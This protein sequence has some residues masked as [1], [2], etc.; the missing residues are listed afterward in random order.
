MKGWNIMGF[1]R[2]EWHSGLTYQQT[3]DKCRT[4]FRYTDYS[5]DYRPWYADGYIDC[6]KCKNHMRH[7]E[8]YAINVPKSQPVNPAFAANTQQTAGV[9]APAQ[10][11]VRPSAPAASVNNK[12]FT[13]VFCVQCGKKY[14]EGDCFCAGCGRKRN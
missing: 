8:A 14:N 9:N 1:K 10:S 4:A 3:C 13:S 12:V 7:N 11:Q 2:A 5:L 6:P